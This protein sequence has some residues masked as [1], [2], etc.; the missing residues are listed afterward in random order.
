[1]AIRV[2]K[3]AKRLGRS[4]AEVLGV[5]HAIGIERYRSPED[6]LSGPVEQKVVRALKDGVKPVSVGVR[7]VAKARPVEAPPEGGLFPG[8]KRVVDDRFE[9]APMAVKKPAPRPQAPVPPVVVVEQP[10]AAPAA[11]PLVDALTLERQALE[12]AQSLLSAEREAL[13]AEREALEASRSRRSDAVSLEAVLDER[14]LRGND[15][16]ERAIRAL[17]ETRRLGEVLPYLTV[18]DPVGLQAYLRAHLHLVDG[19]APST[20]SG[21]LVSVASDRAEIPGAAEWRRLTN[22]LSENLML[23]GARRVLVVGGPIRMHRL[24]ADALD[25]RIEIRFRPTHRVVATDA[26]A[27]VKR[28]DSIALWQVETDAASDAILDSG[29]VVVARIHKPGVKA[30][31]EGWARDLAE[32]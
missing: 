3:L 19:A 8:V 20:L 9:A 22:K 2:R 4:P 27:D 11:S 23:H 24:L 12:A 5:L 30:L 31:L 21:A 13:K 10:I 14:G 18:S 28:T 17:A 1:M 29:R 25:P 15:E 6:M 7:A 32:A 16:H 26:E